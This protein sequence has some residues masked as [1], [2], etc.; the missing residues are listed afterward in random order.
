MVRQVKN[1]RI[2]GLLTFSMYQISKLMEEF[3]VLLAI[4]SVPIT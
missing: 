3:K 4:H 1:F 2:E